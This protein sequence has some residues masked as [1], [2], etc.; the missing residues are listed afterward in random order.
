M[1]GDEQITP[2]DGPTDLDE[3]GNRQPIAAGALED[4]NP[5]AHAGE[6]LPDQQGATS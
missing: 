6:E 5:E 1:A 3:E 4:L 2:Y